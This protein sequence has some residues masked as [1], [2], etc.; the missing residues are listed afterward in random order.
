MEG[1]SLALIVHG[2]RETVLPPVV[3]SRLERGIPATIGRQT[4]L[5]RDRAGWSD[6]RLLRVVERFRVRRDAWTG[7]YE[8]VGRDGALFAADSLATIDVWLQQKPARLAIDRDWARGNGSFWVEQTRIVIPLSAEDLGEVE[9]WLSGELG[10]DGGSILSIP[11]GLLNIL[12][13]MS[14]LGDQKSSA[15][16]ERFNMSAIAG[17]WVWIRLEE[18]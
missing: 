10:G 18:S 3:R 15:R 11:R 17:D 7:I 14:G 9:D 8:I 16:S 13:N 6:Q 4:D 1:D 2:D 12:R 5:W